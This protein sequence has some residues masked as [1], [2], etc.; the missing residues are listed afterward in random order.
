M[1][2][3]TYAA[4]NIPSEWRRMDFGK[5]VQPY[6]MPEWSPMPEMEPGQQN[7]MPAP[8]GGMMPMLPSQPPNMGGL[9]GATHPNQLQMES[10]LDLNDL[11]GPFTN[12]QMA[13]TSLK[14][15]LMRNL[16]FYI[17]AGFLV[18]TRDPVSWEG[19]LYSVGNDYIVIYQPDVDRYITGDLYSLKFV[20]FHNTQNM[21][22]WAGY[23]RREAYNG[24]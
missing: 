23:R 1:P 5:P 12:S 13:K 3:N 6:P 7:Q 19:I 11:D 22:P 4:G 18:G 9:P 24:W 15:L 8:E 16:G 20:E 14:G 2:Q 10:G 17:V 21:T